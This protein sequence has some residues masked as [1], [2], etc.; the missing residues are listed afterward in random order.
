[1]VTLRWELKEAVFS[2][3][4]FLQSHRKESAAGRGGMEQ[5]SGR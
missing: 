4:V 5:A 1:M 3:L 2:L